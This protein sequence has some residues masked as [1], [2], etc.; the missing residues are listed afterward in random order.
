MRAQILI[1]CKAM[2]FPLASCGSTLAKEKYHCVEVAHI[3]RFQVKHLLN[4]EE[5]TLLLVLLSFNIWNHTAV[6]PR[7]FTTDLYILIF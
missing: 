6:L 1:C 2:N 7:P 4:E 5:K 3:S